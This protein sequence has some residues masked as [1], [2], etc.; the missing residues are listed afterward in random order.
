MEVDTP[1]AR[2][3]RGPTG[4]RPGC[5]QR[6]RE[7]GEEGEGERAANGHGH[8]LECRR[9]AEMRPCRCLLLLA[10]LALIALLTSLALFTSI[11]LIAWIALITSNAE[12]AR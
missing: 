1:C 4:N 12:L 9:A 5:A 8:L 10:S 7:E 6:D 2:C 3:D 11:A